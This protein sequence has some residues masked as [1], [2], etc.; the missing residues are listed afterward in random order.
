MKMQNCREF[1]EWIHEMPYII[2]TNSEKF[3]MPTAADIPTDMLNRLDG[4][5]PDFLNCSVDELASLGVVLAHDQRA[6]FL[7]GRPVLLIVDSVMR[8]DPLARGRRKKDPLEKDVQDAM[9]VQVFVV[10]ERLRAWTIAL[11]RRRQTLTV[12][13]QRA[14]IFGQLAD[15]AWVEEPAGSTTE[16]DERRQSFF[17][18]CFDQGSRLVTTWYPWTKEPG[19]LS[20][21]ARN[22]VHAA[23]RTMT[24]CEIE[25]EVER[26]LAR[27]R[28]LLRCYRQATA[29][30]SAAQEGSERLR[31]GMPMTM[32]QLASLAGTATD[33]PT[34]FEA[35]RAAID[36]DFDPSDLFRSLLSYRPLL[37][38]ARKLGRFGRGFDVELEHLDV[39]IMR[40]QIRISAE[41]DEGRHRLQEGITDEEASA[42]LVTSAA[43]EMAPAERWPSVLDTAARNGNSVMLSRDPLRHPG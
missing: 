2:L 12:P 39:V 28:F 37:G 21:V 24:R 8:R 11:H 36:G 22:I 6:A 35:C 19:D 3:A 41:F 1:E 26:E 34:L 42:T 43:Y 13:A 40:R 25:A 29:T 9:S 16:S 15:A 31:T 33:R 27:T 38:L 18:T 32:A 23:A 17:R 10:V 30:T 7:A 5:R 14:R 4:R 20:K